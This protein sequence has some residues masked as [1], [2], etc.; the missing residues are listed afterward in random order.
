MMGGMFGMFNQMV[1]KQKEM[2]P[3]EYEKR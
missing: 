2:E 3:E 1:D